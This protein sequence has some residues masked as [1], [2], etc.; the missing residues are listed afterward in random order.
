[1]DSDQM[2]VVG[3]DGVHLTPTVYSAIETSSFKYANAGPVEEN[4][5][6]MSKAWPDT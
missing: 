1:M 3:Q 6:H 4:L 5:H 2:H